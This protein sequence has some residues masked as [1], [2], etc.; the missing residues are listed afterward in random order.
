MREIHVP[1]MRGNV[2]TL[3]DVTHVA[4]VAMVYNVPEDLFGDSVDLT[5]KRFVNSIK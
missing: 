1:W 5:V 3:S 4:Q 2:E